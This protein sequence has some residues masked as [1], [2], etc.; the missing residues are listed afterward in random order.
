MQR[1]RT[2]GPCNKEEGRSTQ[3]R[4]GGG[5]GAFFTTAHARMEVRLALYTVQPPFL[6]GGFLCQFLLLFRSNATFRLYYSIQ[7]T[8]TI[9]TYPD[10]GRFLHI[11][12]HP[13]S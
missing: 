4:R 7:T 1:G 12:F 5:V 3:R 11:C 9:P 6:V 10:N 13:P 2:A 8:T